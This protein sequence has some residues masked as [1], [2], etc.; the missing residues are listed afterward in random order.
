MSYILQMIEDI[1]VCSAFGMITKNVA[2]TQTVVTHTPVVPVCVWNGSNL[3]VDSVIGYENKKK[4]YTIWHG[5]R[6]F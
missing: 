5:I 3:M 4:S 1:L 2:H 6:V